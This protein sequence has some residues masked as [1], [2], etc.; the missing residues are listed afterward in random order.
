MKDGRVQDAPQLHTISISL[1]DDHNGGCHTEWQWLSYLWGIGHK[2]VNSG[3][4]QPNSGEINLVD[5]HRQTTN[6]RQQVL[7]GFNWPVQG[8]NGLNAAQLSQPRGS[9]LIV[10]HKVGVSC[11]I[12]LRHGVTMHPRGRHSREG[13]IL[14]S[15][16]ITQLTARGQQPVTTTQYNHLHNN[17]NNWWRPWD[18][19]SIKEEGV[20]P[21]TKH[22][23]IV[24]RRC[25]REH[26]SPCETSVGGALHHD[27]AY[28]FGEFGQEAEPT[29]DVPGES[30]DSRLSPYKA[31]SNMVSQRD[32]GRRATVRRKP[33]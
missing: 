7:R 13:M 18:E 4:D 14:L 12:G 16:G 27:W 28:K 2:S 9:T 3:E 22:Q 31:L 29:R 10:Q 1:D 20:G 6:V 25:Y 5:G 32:N 33:P 15:H 11:G 26:R 30:C 23:D 21:R 17:R 24:S 8:Y 19:G